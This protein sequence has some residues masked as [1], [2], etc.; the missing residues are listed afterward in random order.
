MCCCSWVSCP[1]TSSIP[2]IGQHK[3][4]GTLTTKWV[5]EMRIRQGAWLP[6]RLWGG[7]GQNEAR[8]TVARVKWGL[9]IGQSQ[10][11]HH[12]AGSPARYLDPRNEGGKSEY[13]W[14]S[15]EAECLPAAAPKDHRPWW[16]LFPEGNHDTVS[17]EG[18][19]HNP[20]PY[21]TG[22]YNSSCTHWRD[23]VS[24]PTWEPEPQGRGMTVYWPWGADTPRFQSM[25]VIHQLSNLWNLCVRA[26]ISS[27]KW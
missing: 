8:Q 16:V 5:F 25:G 11:R 17:I 24:P 2:Q 10:L 27:C 20:S 14:W 1:M 6:S 4:E 13:R 3:L 19:F 26:S 7:L 9:R 21:Q 18:W 23:I 15:T 12:L 22:A